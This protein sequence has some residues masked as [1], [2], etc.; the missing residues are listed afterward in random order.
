MYAFSL[1]LKPIFIVDHVPDLNS[2]ISI[3]NSLIDVLWPYVHTGPLTTDNLPY[4]LVEKYDIKRD[5][6]A[7]C[8]T[9]SVLLWLGSYGNIVKRKEDLKAIGLRISR[10][11]PSEE[12]MES[13]AESM[14]RTAYMQ[15]HC[16]G[17]E[18]LIGLVDEGFVQKV[19][20]LK[21]LARQYQKDNLDD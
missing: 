17:F 7:F 16:K 6:G 11:L 2:V 12:C 9:F 19:K 18:Q 10:I 13:A 8:Y 4:G 20:G 3:A 14:T 1:L 21:E 5:V 15:L